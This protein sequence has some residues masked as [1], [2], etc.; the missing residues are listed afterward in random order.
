MQM[1]S[2]RSRAV[3]THARVAPFRQ[4]AR[5]LLGCALAALLAAAPALHASETVT[6]KGNLSDGG[7]GATGTY[8][9]RVQLFDQPVGGLPLSAQIE[10]PSVAVSNGAFQVPLEL[11][12]KLP[13]DRSVW[14]QAQIKPPGG[15]D[16]QALVGREEINATLGG[17]CW[18]LT[19]NTGVP[20]GARV[21]VS[22]TNTPL[23]AVGNASSLLYMRQGGGIEQDNATAAGVSSVAFNGNSTA[24]GNNSLAAGRGATAAGHN[25]S[26]VFGDGQPGQFMSTLA[27]QFLVR[28]QNGVGINTNAPIGTLSVRRGGASGAAS[29]S[30]SV[31]TGESDSSTYLTLLTPASQERGVLF[32]DPT[33][34]ASGGVLYNTAANPNG[35]TLRTGGNIDRLRLS[36]S[37]KLLLNAPNE[38][39]TTLSDMVL[40]SAD[41][42]AFTVEMQPSTGT[43][44]RIDVGNQTFQ[45]TPLFAGGVAQVN[46]NWGIGR[47]PNTN[48]LEVAGAASKDTAG[49]WLANSDRRI[50]TEVAPIDN[51]LALINRVQPV[52]FRYDTEYRKAHPGIADQRYY[53]VIAQDFA[54]VFPDAVKGSGDYLP[55]KARTPEHQILQVDTYPATIA[56]IAAIQ[57]LDAKSSL[58]A[59]RLRQ[60]EAENASLNARLIAL[61]RALGASR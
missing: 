33:N 36:N 61:E 38:P 25:Y 1:S 50:K 42:G 10:L 39:L 51:A 40:R 31:I 52:T 45:L 29:A 20:N 26:M 23:I 48:R 7:K 18:E 4:H 17:T 8:G 55:G 28:A 56:S 30:A 54:R 6:Y 53:N 9:L 13:A 24:S 47:T 5:R 46:S 57:E 12:G 21:G 14:L 37:G 27:N 58:Q 49:A 59:Q 3:S 15:Q 19:G 32:G 2:L 34:V 44:F 41:A 16:F 60:L 35:M 11:P 43:G 22:D